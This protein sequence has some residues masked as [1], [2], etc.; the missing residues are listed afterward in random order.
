MIVVSNSTILIGLAK[1]NKLDLLKKL[2]SKIYIP[3]AVFNELTHVEK[4]GASE[5]KKASYL[6]QKSPEDG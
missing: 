3:D 5:I 6:V 1:I 2:F 4:T